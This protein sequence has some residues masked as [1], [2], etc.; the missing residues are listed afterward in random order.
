MRA[1]VDT[2]EHYNPGWKFNDWEQ[3][4]VPLRIE[5]GP[6]DLASQQV[7][8]ARRD[9]LSPAGKKAVAWAEVAPRAVE[10]VGVRQR[11]EVAGGHSGSAAGARAEGARQPYSVGEHVERVREGAR[12][13]HGVGSVV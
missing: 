11:C 5:L 8:F 9:I 2:R 7:V 4:G 3:K 1:E 13:E 6:K 10:E 12:W